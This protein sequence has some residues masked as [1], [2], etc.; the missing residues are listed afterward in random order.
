MF[1][2]YIVNKNLLDPLSFKIKCS[3]SEQH[4]FTTK[5]M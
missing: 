4:L 1:Y 2:L 5:Y 3:E